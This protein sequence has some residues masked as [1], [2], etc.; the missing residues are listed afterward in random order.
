MP[1]APR[2]HARAGLSH[3]AFP[4]I[5]DR[6]IDVL[7]RE[8]RFRL[9]ALWLAC[10]SQA[11]S[12]QEPVLRRG[13]FVRAVLDHNPS[14]AATHH[15]WRAALARGREE[16]GFDEPMVEFGMAPL[17][18]GADHH[19]F[20]YEVALSQKLPWF[21]KR[22]LSEAIASAEAD[23]TH[24][25]LE[26][27][28]QALALAA[29]L[30]YE[31]YA[32]AVRSLQINAQHVELLRTL[33]DAAGTQLSAGQAGIGDALRVEAELGRMERDALTL[34]AQRDV[35]AA[36]MNE[37]LHRPPEQPLLPPSAEFARA[38]ELPPD[39]LRTLTAEAARSRPEVA[40]ARHRAR[41]EQARAERAGR[42]YYPDL[43]L[44]TSYSSMWDAPEHRFMIGLG[45]QLPLGLG[46]RAA[47]ADEAQAARARFES[48]ALAASDAARTQIF[49]AI[50][51]MQR[52][53]D[54]LELLEARLLPL[55]SDQV[56]AARGAFVASRGTFTSVLEAQRE[57][58]NTQ[59]DQ[60]LA[61]AEY[62]RQRAELDR[63]LGRLPGL[64]WEGKSR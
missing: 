22:G 24:S 23:A 52:A 17:S 42:E 45:V 47:A 3:F 38:P 5:D 48:E 55:A 49:V 57:L 25:E 6:S 40:A 16:G 33:R 2:S 50:R 19:P 26:S 4:V 61:R 14:L 20:G 10:L 39:D 34:A 27:T 64:D 31:D 59:L 32:V 44:S 46:R 63:A 8:H 51:Q 36:Q 7:N 12:A 37:L 60:Q 28:R 56:E 62:H 1:C 54:A 30:L 29:V 41:G 13:D 15:A 53:R 11:G 21:G 18:I 9:V 35:T 58:R 43:M